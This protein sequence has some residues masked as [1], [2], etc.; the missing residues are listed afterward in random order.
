[1]SSQSRLLMQGASQ[2]GQFIFRLTKGTGAATLPPELQP[3]DLPANLPGP[4]G[5]ASSP[6]STWTMRPTGTR[7]YDVDT[8]TDDLWWALHDLVDGLF[9]SAAT[10]HVLLQWGAE[11]VEGV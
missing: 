11:P 4:Q 6:C 7:G 10:S 1:M 9:R 2:H 3:S 5:S 8:I